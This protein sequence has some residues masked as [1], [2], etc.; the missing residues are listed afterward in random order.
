MA[1]LCFICE[2]PL[3]PHQ[4]WSVWRE[5]DLL[6]AS[7]TI[8]SGGNYVNTHFH[9]DCLTCSVCG[10]RL[11]QGETNPNGAK[12]YGS[13]VYCALHYADISGVGTGGT[14]FMAKLKDFKRQSLGKC[15]NSFQKGQIFLIPYLF[16]QKAMRKREERVAQH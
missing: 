15:W 14:E 2:L 13:K 11:K 3:L 12:R 6:T 4:T 1:K 7:G 5:S 16:S 9:E 10:L 8:S